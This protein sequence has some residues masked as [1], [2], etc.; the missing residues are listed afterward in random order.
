MSFSKTMPTSLQT[1]FDK[2]KTSG[3]LPSP[4]GVAVLPGTAAGAGGE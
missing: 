3:L 2:F 4:K 1:R